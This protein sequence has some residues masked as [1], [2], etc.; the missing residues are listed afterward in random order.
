MKELDDNYTAIGISQALHTKTTN[1]TLKK[2]FKSAATSATK[3]K[4]KGTRKKGGAS[5]PAVLKKSDLCHIQGQHHVVD[6][7]AKSSCEHCKSFDTI[8]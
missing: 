1:E 8:H 4:G 7:S 6:S 5:Y 2:L 3:G